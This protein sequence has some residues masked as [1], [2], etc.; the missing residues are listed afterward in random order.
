MPPKSIRIGTRGS[1]LA[2]AQ[3]AIVESALKTHYPDAEITTHEIT[4]QGDKD[5]LTPLYE[6]GGK[7]IFIKEVEA[8]LVS[9]EID[10]AVHSFKDITTNIAPGTIL[11]AYLKPESQADCLVS[12]KYKS[13]EDIP[14][15]AIIETASLR[16]KAL[17]KD[18]F[19]TLKTRDIRGN[20]GTRLKKHIALADSAAVMLSEAGLIRLSLS[21]QIIHRFPPTQFLPAPGQGVITLQCRENDTETA[22]S[23]KAITDP[24]QTQISNLEF[25]LLKEIEFNCSV[26]LGVYS[27][28]ESGKLKIQIHVSHPNTH[29][30]LKL[31]KEISLEQAKKEIKTLGKTL[32]EWMSL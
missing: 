1:K 4:T 29:Q 19:P 12:T 24:Q 13:L 2:L 5:T 32:K 22:S 31:D 16:R 7:G 23:C 8:A 28:I 10:I 6:L 27:Q 17:L 26:P 30:I 3:A 15:G 25:A 20:V 14:D 9:N 18:H 21:D 11:S